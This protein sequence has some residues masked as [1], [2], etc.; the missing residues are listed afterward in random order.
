MTGNGFSVDPG[1]LGYWAER[2]R[3]ARDDVDEALAAVPVTV[4]SGGPVDRKLERV[5]AGL[6]TEGG[7]VADHLHAVQANVDAA[8]RDYLD[9]DDH[10]ARHLWTIGDDR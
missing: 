9:V 4:D 6:V 2:I 1:S 5:L 8:V 7:L 10:H 3:T